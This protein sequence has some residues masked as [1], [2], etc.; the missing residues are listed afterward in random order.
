MY[1]GKIISIPAHKLH[2]YRCTDTKPLLTKT[3][4]KQGKI[5]CG[6]SCAEF[7]A[8]RE[9]DQGEVRRKHNSV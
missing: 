8:R 7:T 5:Y 4:Q 6:D 2:K 1:K 3:A 9:N